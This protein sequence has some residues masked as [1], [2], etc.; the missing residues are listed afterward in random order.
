MTTIT[1]SELR[2]ELFHALATVGAGTVLSVTLK[3]REV[4]RLVPVPGRDWRQGMRFRPRL[5]V[6]V[7]QAF[8]PLTDDWEGYL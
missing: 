4:A 7:D 1:A 3:G 8:A 6:P 5:L 2:R